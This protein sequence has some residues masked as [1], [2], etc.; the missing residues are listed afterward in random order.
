MNKKVRLRL[1]VMEGRV[2]SLSVLFLLLVSVGSIVV[3]VL[4]HLCLFFR[5]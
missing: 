3:G 2:S 1:Y 4:P 5:S